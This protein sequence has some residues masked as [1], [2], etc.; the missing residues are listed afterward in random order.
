MIDLTNRDMCPNCPG[1]LAILTN[2]TREDD[3][4]Y[5][6]RQLDGAD[7]YAGI[8]GG[9]ER[10]IEVSRMVLS[11]G[12]IADPANGNRGIVCPKIRMW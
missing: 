4:R 10:T 9:P 2:G 3:L 11:N 12:K 1:H 6:L 8:V 5:A 7:Q